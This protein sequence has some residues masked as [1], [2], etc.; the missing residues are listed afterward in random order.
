ME[1]KITPRRTYL[2]VYLALLVLLA[3]TV[4]ASFLDLGILHTPVAITIAFIKAMLVLLFFMGL[5]HSD[6]L[7]RLYA[8]AGFIWLLILFSLTLTD[9]LTRVWVSPLFPGLQR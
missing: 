2:L 3:M 1:E 9:Y 7:T 6:N 8:A 4:G 5:R